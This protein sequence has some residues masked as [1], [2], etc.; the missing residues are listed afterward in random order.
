MKIAIINPTTTPPM[1]EGLGQAAR[2]AA[3]S[4]TEILVR[5]SL[6]GPTGI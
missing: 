4:D 5:Q 1:T 3:R 2:S 6:R